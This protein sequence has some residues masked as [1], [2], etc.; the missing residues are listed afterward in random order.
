MPAIGGR[1]RGIR[2][3]ARQQSRRNRMQ[4]NISLQFRIFSYNVHTPSRGRGQLIHVKGTHA[5]TRYTYWAHSFSHCG[6]NIRALFFLGR[7]GLPPAEPDTADS[8]CSFGT[9]CWTSV[10]TIGHR[11]NSRELGIGIVAYSPLGRGFFSSG[12]KLIDSLSGQ[13]IRKVNFRDF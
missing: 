10:L 5:R 12:S 1:E 13:D 2:A 4:T 11:D 9:E 8:T 7:S 6:P 3:R